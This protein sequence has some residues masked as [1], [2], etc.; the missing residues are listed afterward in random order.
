MNKKQITI[1]PFQLEGMENSF[2][3][4]TSVGIKTFVYD[5]KE[6]MERNKIKLTNLLKQK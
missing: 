1:L 4:L 5:T 3:I 2:T 6:D